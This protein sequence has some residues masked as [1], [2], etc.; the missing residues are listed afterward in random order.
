MLDC[1]Y[2]KEGYEN[3]ANARR[4]ILKMKKRGTLYKG[5]KVYK[6]MY[7]GFYHIGSSFKGEMKGKVHG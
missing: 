6:C 1:C 5:V 4:V 3:P 7:C 2:G